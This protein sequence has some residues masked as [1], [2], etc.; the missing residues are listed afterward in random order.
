[1][2]APK[3]VLLSI[4]VILYVFSFVSCTEFEAGGENGWNIPQSSNQSDM[5][6]QWASKN[7]FKVGDTIRK[8][9]FYIIYQL[10]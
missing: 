9:F 4:F 3:I 6:N 2:G 10:L 5:F 8:N 1:M 7:R